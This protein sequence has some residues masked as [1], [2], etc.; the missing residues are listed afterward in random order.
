[1]TFSATID[2][3]GRAATGIRVPAGVVASLGPSG[4]HAVRVTIGSHTY[5]S[6]IAARDGRYVI[7]V[8]AVNR[9]EAGIVAGIRVEVV[10]EPD[11]AEAPA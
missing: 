6:T 2:S 10:L 7:P 3:D 1:M 5:R 8:S 11:G 9:E 4:P